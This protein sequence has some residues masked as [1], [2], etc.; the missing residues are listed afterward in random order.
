MK[1]FNTQGFI[2]F[3][4]T[5]ESNR[6]SAQ[7]EMCAQGVAVTL[8]HS[9]GVEFK[10]VSGCYKGET[11]QSYVVSALQAPLVRQLCNAFH[12]E[13]FLRVDE[14]NLAELVYLEEDRYEVIG[15]LFEVDKYTA[16]K[17]DAYTYD[18]TTQQYYIVE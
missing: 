2:I 15:E 11:E 7:K 4:V 16:L 8:M 18:Q 12:Q 10:T 14:N 6:L 5:N 1:L 9:L 17:Q 3:S 13:S